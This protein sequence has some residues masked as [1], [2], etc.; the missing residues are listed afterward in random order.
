MKDVLKN[1][2]FLFSFFLIPVILINATK[3]IVPAILLLIVS[4]IPHFKKPSLNEIPKGIVVLLLFYCLHGL[5]LMNSDNLAYASSDLETKLSF[6]I[7]PLF[8]LFT[9]RSIG[10]KHLLSTK[11]GFILGSGFAMIHSLLNALICNYSGGTTCFYPADFGFQMHGTYLTAI[12][13]FSAFLL[14]R[15]PLKFKFK[16]AIY[17]GYLLLLLISLYYV[18]SLSSLVC[19]FVLIVLLV[20]KYFKE[21]ESRKLKFLLFISVVGIVGL[22]CQLGPIKGDIKNTT[23][24]IKEYL[25]N[26]QEYIENKREDHSSS[27]SRV[28]L[29]TMSME[30]ICNNP[31]GVGIGDVKDKLYEVYRKY[32]YTHFITKKYNSHSQFFQTTIALGYIGLVFL[33][34][35]LIHPILG[36]RKVANLDLFVLAII[37]IVSCAFESFLERQV[38]VIFFS[39]A[40]YVFSKPSIKELKK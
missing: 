20:M 32:D 26:R 27:T 22:A 3:L 10:E 6:L 36:Q 13:L 4:G 28:L 33:I 7:F 11:Y 1:R 23:K 37:L 21:L 16:I 5:G 17:V 35:L 2:V 8:Y 9:Y 30:I 19:V 25:G 15:I 40:L 31:M 39:F 14:F 38:G 29:Y 34:Y 18:R 12:Y 24:T